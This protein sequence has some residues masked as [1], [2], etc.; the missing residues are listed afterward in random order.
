MFSV[1]YYKSGWTGSNYIKT[2]LEKF[3]NKPW[4]WYWLSRNPSVA[5]WEIVTDK[6]WDWRTL[7][8]NP[9]IA[10]WKNIKDNSSFPWDW[11][12]KRPYR[13]GLSHILDVTWEIIRDN[14]DKSWDWTYLST[15]PNITR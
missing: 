4:N 11:E 13:E 14:P 15:N 8:R 3:P 7:S 10:T 1:N 5:T 6:P 12:R 2:L 9:N